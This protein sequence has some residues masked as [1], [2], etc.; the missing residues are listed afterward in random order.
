M[1]EELA[2]MFRVRKTVIKMLAD[3]GYLLSREELDL[4]FDQFKAQVAGEATVLYV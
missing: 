1:E 4:P 3:R 2:L